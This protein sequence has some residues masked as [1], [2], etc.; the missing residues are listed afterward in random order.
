MTGRGPL[1]ALTALAAPVALGF[2][3]LL[4]WALFPPDFELVRQ[5]AEPVL[6]PIAWVLCAVCAGAGV[7]G[8]RMQR[9]MTARAVARLGPRAS[10]PAEVERAKVGAFLLAS[11][12][13][14]VPAI[15][16]T[17]LFMFGAALFPVALAVGIATLAVV[18]LAVKG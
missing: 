3:T 2:E 5:W 4:R 1:I 9:R 17:L 11:S 14:Q 18:V 6:T 8:L 10:I 13:A 12:V 7:L 15:A 16:A